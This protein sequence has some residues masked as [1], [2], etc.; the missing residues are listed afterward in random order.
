V[1]DGATPTVRQRFTIAHEICHTF[2][3]EI[4]PELKFKPHSEPSWTGEHGP[5]S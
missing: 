2:F 3:Y 4:V 1:L 5:S